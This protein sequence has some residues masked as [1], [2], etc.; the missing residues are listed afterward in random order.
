MRLKLKLLSV[1]LWS[2]FTG[3]QRM[4]KWQMIHENDQALTEEHLRTWLENKMN[5]LDQYSKQHAYHTFEQPPPLNWL[6]EFTPMLNK[7]TLLATA[8]PPVVGDLTTLVSDQ[9]GFKIHLAD[10]TQF[11]PN[12]SVIMKK[13]P[14]E[15]RLLM[16]RRREY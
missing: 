10:F 4:V 6:T 1:E 12:I 9:C 14:F 8:T 7:L 11:R 15:H 13:L 16:E 3:F 5:D 2:E